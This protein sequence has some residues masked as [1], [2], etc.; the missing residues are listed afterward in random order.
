MMPG[1]V[2]GAGELVCAVGGAGG[3]GDLVI[4]G[5]GIALK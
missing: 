5:R 4:E 1:P 3:G 2:A